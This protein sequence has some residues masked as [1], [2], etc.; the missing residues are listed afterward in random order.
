LFKQLNIKYSDSFFYGKSGYAFY[1]NYTSGIYA[2]EV[3][4]QLKALNPSNQH[5]SLQAS[6]CGTF[7]CSSGKS[8]H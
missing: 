1:S 6:F 5:L 3:K 2:P 7:T 8:H 4:N